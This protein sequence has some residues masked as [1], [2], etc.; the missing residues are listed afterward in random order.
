MVHI[1]DNISQ[2]ILMSSSIEGTIKLW[3]IDGNKLVL[4]TEATDGFSKCFKNNTNFE[5]EFLSK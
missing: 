3:R 2:L 4:N 1:L 5:V